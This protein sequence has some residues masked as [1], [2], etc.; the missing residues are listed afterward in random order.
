MA[1]DAALLVDP[2]QPEAIAEAILAVAGSPQERQRL[3]DLGIARSR[4]FSL[5]N[6]AIQTADVYR[7]VGEGRRPASPREAGL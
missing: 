6:M 5:R 2:E 4:G 3:A 7:R 1:G